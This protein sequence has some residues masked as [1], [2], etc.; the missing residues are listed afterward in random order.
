MSD[1]EKNDGQIT[2]SHNPH[3]G[4]RERMR[5]RFLATGFEDFSEHEILEFMLYYVH[6]RANTNEIG[7]ALLEQFGSLKAVVQADYHDLLQVK[8]VGQQGAVFLKMLPELIKAYDGSDLD[9]HCLLADRDKERFFYQKLRME[10]DEVVLIACLSEKMYLLECAEIG[11]GTPNRV[12]VNFRKMVQVILR[13]HTTCVI[14]AHN[15]P[16]GRAVATYED[17]MTTNHVRTYLKTIGVDL[18]DHYIV[19]D[20]KA[21]SMRRTGAY[22][23]I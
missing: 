16:Q 13:N 20:G 10:T 9:P 18:L 7:H 15:H 3:A 8:G 2:S 17:T 6:K 12:S 22:L 14:M 5:K 23:P 1:K 4:H 21:V 19:A 11:R